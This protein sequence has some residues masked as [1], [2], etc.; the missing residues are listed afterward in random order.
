MLGGVDDGLYE[1]LRTAGLERHLQAL[2]AGAATFGSIDKAAAPD[3]LAR[4]VAEIVRR[5]L[6]AH[7]DEPRRQA[8]VNGIVEL[9]EGSGD[10]TVV[11]LEQ[12]LAVSVAPGVHRVVRPAMPLSDTALLTNTKD[13]PSL[14][15]ELQA[16]IA[17]ADRV[18]LLCAFVKWHGMRL[19]SD[20]F[21]DLKARG[22]PLRVLTTT[23]LGGTER[24]AVDELVHP[25]GAEVKIR[26]EEQ[27]TRLQAKAWLFRRRSGFDTGYVGSST[28]S[29]SALVDGLNGTSASPRWRPR[30]SSGSR[31]HLRH[32]LEQP[33]VPALRPGPRRRPP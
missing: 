11:T 12:L 13:E 10:D 24:H 26:F 21:D 17:S 18:D 29:K 5:S 30:P 19:L 14:G 23:Y 3:V 7:D 28:L 25:Y 16:E 2:P 15:A 32:V 20:Q 9:L 6:S 33:R 31:S 27:S 8:L 22:K 1:S 4:H